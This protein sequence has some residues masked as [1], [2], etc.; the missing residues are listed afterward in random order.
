MIALARRGE[1]GEDPLAVAL[2]IGSLAA[3]AFDYGAV[4]AAS[5]FVDLWSGRDEWSVPD[6]AL[7]GS[8]FL[9]TL[10]AAAARV[11]DDLRA[12]MP[13]QSRALITALERKQHECL[14]C[15]FVMAVRPYDD[16]DTPSYAACPCCA[17][18]YGVTE[19]SG[20]DPR[21]WRERWIRAGMPFRSGDPAADW[22]PIAQMYA[23]GIA[24]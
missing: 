10:D 19:H 3:A 22:A 23:A 15:G 2:E 5:P 7:W 13:A 20:D 24:P 18:D 14:A 21:A 16:D 12:V 4:A 1:Q 11:A 17:Y 8:A 6:R 9:H